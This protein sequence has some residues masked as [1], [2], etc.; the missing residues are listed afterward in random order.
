M[1]S[2]LVNVFDVCLFESVLEFLESLIVI[3]S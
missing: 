1:Y 3:A 2:V